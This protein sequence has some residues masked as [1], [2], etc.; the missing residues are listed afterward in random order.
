M[1]HIVT[2]SLWYYTVVIRHSV[3]PSCHCLGAELPVSP[4]PTPLS[5][6]INYQYHRTKESRTTECREPFRDFRLFPPGPGQSVLLPSANSADAKMQR[7]DLTFTIYKSGNHL[8]KQP[9]NWNPVTQC[10]KLFFPSI[11][12]NQARYKVPIQYFVLHNLIADRQLAH[13]EHCTNTCLPQLA[14]RLRGYSHVLFFFRSLISRLFC[15]QWT[16]SC[17]GSTVSRVSTQKCWLNCNGMCI[18]HLRKY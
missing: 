2:M 5:N 1:R 7:N 6:G 13:A 3:A 11:K 4:P 14:E 9:F 12:L 15:S 8:K 18:Y 16:K 10:A 17:F